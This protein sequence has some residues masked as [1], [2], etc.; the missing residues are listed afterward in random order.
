MRNIQLLIQYDGTRYK[1]WQSQDN[2]EQTIQGRLTKVL[3]RMLGET[4]ELQGS[5]RTD[6]GVHAAGQV[7]NFRTMTPLSCDELLRDINQFLPEDMAV[8]EVRDADLRFHSRL[9]ALRKTYV[10]RIWNSSVSNVFE[11]KYLYQVKEPLDVTAM[12]QAAALLCG[13]HDFRA[14]CA[15]KR[16][17]KSTVRTLE[18]IEIER[19]GQE[20][21]LSFTGNGFLYHM[22]RIMVGTLLEV[23]LGKRRWE[24][25]PQLLET[26]E[27]ACSGV[28]A[29][30]QG[31]CLL[32]VEY[33]DGEAFRSGRAY[34]GGRL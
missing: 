10:Y 16:M 22:V 29:P 8:T 21:R 5:G 6:A 25:M 17:K 7:A 15:N 4:I 23:G 32:R 31:L 14:F 13:T 2:T 33:K 24:E 19:Y 34:H 1:G 3:E 28:L 12:K 18:H 11:R 27:R 20:L 30:A 9:H 26:G